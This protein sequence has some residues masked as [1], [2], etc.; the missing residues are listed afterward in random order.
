MP[1]DQG[2]NG[3]MWTEE[4]T[5]LLLKLGWTKVGDSNVDVKNEEEKKNGLD[6]MFIYKDPKRNTNISEGIVLEAKRYLTTSLNI[7]ALH[8][9][10]ITLDKK[11]TKIKNSG[12]FQSTFP[13]I[14]S[15]AIQNGLIVLW[16][17]DLENFSAFEKIFKEKFPSI[18]LPFK[19]NT[20]TPNHIFV[21]LNSDILRLCSL[22]DMI[23]KLNAANKKSPIKFYYPS[24][25]YFNNAVAR[26]ETLTI[27]YI[28]SKFILAESI[29]RRTEN[30]FIFYFGELSI[31]AFERLK[32]FLLENSFIE[33]KSPLTIYTYFRNE[34]FRKIKPDV[35]TLFKKLCI[36]TKIEEMTLYSDLPPFLKE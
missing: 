35:I 31:Q 36:T 1:E 32:S 16:I 26:S 34:E 18:K 9:F 17:S 24:S 13:R 6:A 25:D 29:I 27:D 20:A 30:K 33:K 10:I 5:R 11:L 7:S 8:E 3:D 21:L 14:G 4:A 2:V 22:I 19:S 15:A 28:F 23:E 12:N